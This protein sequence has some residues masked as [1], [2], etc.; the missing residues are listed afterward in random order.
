MV[1]SDRLDVELRPNPEPRPVTIS[2]MMW[3][4]LGLVAI[5]GIRQYASEP[6]SGTFLNYL[7]PNQITVSRSEDAE[8]QFPRLGVRVAVSDGWAY[9]STSQDSLAFTPTFSHAKSNLILRLQPFHLDQWPPEGAQPENIE[10][11]GVEMQ[12]VPVGRLMVGRWVTGEVDLA[13]VVIGHQQKAAIAP[14]VVE[15]C[16]R[17]Q[18][19]AD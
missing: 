16:R 18:V 11:E 15:F 5:I 4:A 1:V 2:P 7:T 14:S 12:W 19:I 6:Q 8:H 3:I 17:V 10:V 13:V 9:L